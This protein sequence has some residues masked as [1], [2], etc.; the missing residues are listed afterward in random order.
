METGVFPSLMKT[1]KVVPLYKSKMRDEATNYRPISLLLTLSKILEKTIYSRVYSFLNETGQLYSSQ[2]G[3]RK[4]HAC[5]H[6]VGELVGKIT[7]GIQ[8]GKLTIGIFLDLSKVFDS[9][10]HEAI[11]KKM[12]KYG[13]RGNCLMWFK[14]YLSDRKLLVSCRTADSATTNTSTLHEVE[15]GTAQGSC[16]GPLIF[17]IFCNDL[18]RHLT[19]LECIQFADDTTLYITHNN[20]Q[21]IRFCVDHALNILQDWFLGKQTHS[22]CR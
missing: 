17:L 21:Y 11:Y 6:A 14:S 12:E 9:L 10:E 22:Q 15:Y 13:L 19:F 7:K 4:Q 2:Y 20:M 3:F 16:L 8:Q 18:Y 5:E 1:A